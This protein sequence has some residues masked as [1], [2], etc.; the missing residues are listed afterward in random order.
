MASLL[1]IRT[2]FA[3]LC[4]IYLALICISTGCSHK[5]EEI[6]LEGI[7][8]TIPYHIILAGGNATEEAARHVIVDTFRN[9]DVVFNKWNP[10]S[11]ISQLNNFTT[12][13][14]FPCSQ[15]LFSMLLQC[16]RFATISHGLFDPTVEP[17]ERVWKRALDKGTIP[18]KEEIDA[19]FPALGWDKIHLAECSVI[20]EHP[21]TALD[22]GGI[23]KGHA[24]DL[25]VERLAKQGFSS[26]YVEWGGEIRTQGKH[27]ENR[28]W[29]IGIRHPQKTNTV[30]EILETESTAL[31]TSGDYY[32]YWT[33]DVNGEKKRF[34]HIFDIR[35]LQPLEATSTSP[36]SVTI[37]HKSC[38]VADAIAKMFFF[39]QSKDEAMLLFE[40]YI[41]PMFPSARIWVYSHEDNL[42]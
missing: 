39:A 14:P 1:H 24:V 13:E 8:M 5:K 36:V 35:Q 19:I 10:N 29:K 2:L 4:H 27:P 3:A 33:I 25:L 31:A 38:L 17:L 12:T 18:T 6:H 23:A 16:D 28:P 40:H 41:R 30:L 34:F 37:Q 7:A 21:L 42:S 9:I 15:E 11:E 20:K 26:V 22:L 32:Q